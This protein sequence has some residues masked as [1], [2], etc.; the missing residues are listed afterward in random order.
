MN[1]TLLNNLTNFCAKSFRRYQVI[2][3]YVLGHFFS[4]TLY[5]TLLYYSS[6]ARDD[7]RG[8]APF[9]NLPHCG[10]KMQC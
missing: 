5:M 1:T 9:K 4:R 2:T 7:S 3:F 10:N 8:A 6:A